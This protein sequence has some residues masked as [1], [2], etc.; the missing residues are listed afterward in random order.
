MTLKNHVILITGAA[1]GL[2]SA[3][4]LQ[5]AEL[6]A[7]LLLLDKNMSALARLSDKLV[8]A[9]HREP[10]I[11]EMDLSRAQTSEFEELAAL[12]DGEF[13]ALDAVIHCA[14]EFDGLRPLEHTTRDHWDASLNVNLLSAWHIVTACLPH[15]RASGKGRIVLI[16][17]NSAVTKSAYWGPYGVSKAA[18]KSLAQVMSEE[19]E[20]T[21]VEL[22]WTV[23]EPM[24]TGLRARA[25]LSEDPATLRE[26]AGVADEIIQS[27]TASFAAG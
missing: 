7:E 8:A 21:G 11:C 17:E 18:L 24:A 23:P 13:G 20:G 27:L 1:G 5:C 3:L 12:V 14:A 2:G 4:A 6:G 22:I 16:G 9:G 15:L 26:P 25:Y 19:L 10:A